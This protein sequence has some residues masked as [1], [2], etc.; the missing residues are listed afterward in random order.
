MP[1][2]N[3]KTDKNKWERLNIFIISLRRK[4]SLS[5]TNTSWNFKTQGTWPWWYISNQRLCFGKY[6]IISRLE[7]HLF[8][9]H[10]IIYVICSSF[11]YGTPFLKGSL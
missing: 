10:V 11:V 3:N 6:T 4:K 1:Q 2:N 9:N 5:I 8:V 7:N